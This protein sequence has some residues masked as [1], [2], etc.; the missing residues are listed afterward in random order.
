MFLEVND[1]NPNSLYIKQAVKH[2]KEGG[3][4]IFP[5]DTIYG[6]GCDITKPKAI[7]R[8]A[9]IKNVKPEK[10]AFSFSEK[11]LKIP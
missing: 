2:L 11:T 1:K 7:D 8:V 4:I 3:I 9:R 10:A 5:T 6:I